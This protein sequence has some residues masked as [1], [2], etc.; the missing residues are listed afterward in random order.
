M[1]DELGKKLSLLRSSQAKSNFENPFD[2][3]ININEPLY[4]RRESKSEDSNEPKKKKVKKSYFEKSMEMTSNMIKSGD[5][6]ARAADLDE[7]LEYGSEDD[8]DRELHNRLVALGR[9]YSR[10]T[11]VTGDTSE[12]TRAYSDAEKKLKDLIEDIDNDKEK[13]EKDI[14]RLR[15]LRSPNYKSL[16]ELVEAK[17][18]IQNIRLSAIKEMNNITKT[19]FDLKLKASKIDSE[20]AGGDSA[21]T[22]STIQQILG[23][24][25]E[26]ILGLMGGYSGVSGARFASDDDDDFDGAN[27]IFDDEDDEEIQ[28]KYFSNVNDVE[29]EGD[30]YLKY[31]SLGVELILLYDQETGYKEIIAEDKN[32]NIVPDY[33]LPD[34]S[35]RTFDIS[36]K[37]GTA[38]D[39]YQLTYKL[40]LQ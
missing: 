26:N 1:A 40:R 21:T 39:N 34:I 25:R 31:E 33:P 27:G 9:K 29:D 20:N 8:E 2:D 6:T 16:S 28:K 22:S 35:N 30:K 24:G 38:T 11:A 15:T 13:I 4:I 14:S 12:I 36:E 23:S 19:Q 17:T 7:Y 3:E 37:T 32:G 5:I 18:T 10:D